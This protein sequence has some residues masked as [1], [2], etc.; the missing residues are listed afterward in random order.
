MSGI[1]SSQF[2]WAINPSRLQI[3]RLKMLEYRRSL[4]ESRKKGDLWAC[5][6]MNTLIRLLYLYW[7]R[8]Y[9]RRCLLRCIANFC[10][11]WDYPLATYG[12]QAEGNLRAP[13]K[14]F[15]LSSSGQVIS[16]GSLERARQHYLAAHCVCHLAKCQNV[17]GRR[18]NFV[19]LGGKLHF[20]VIVWGA[21]GGN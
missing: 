17:R 6:K 10:S 14:L 18:Q 1:A 19:C 7:F 8:V 16:R 3:T 5:G 9:T 2:A 12:E 13:L 4:M 15:C 20:N 11:K 21:G